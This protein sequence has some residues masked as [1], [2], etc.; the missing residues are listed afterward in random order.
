MRRAF[1]PGILALWAITSPLAPSWALDDVVTLGGFSL[2]IEG[3]I[4]GRAI[5]SGDIKSW[6]DGGLGKI[7]YGGGDGKTG[8]LA[9]A[10][11]ALVLEPKFGFD[12]SGAVVLTANA[13]QRTAVDISE[14][15]LQ[16]KPAPTGA[17][18]LK[19]KAG[20]F[21]PPISRENTGLAWT[22]PYTLTS[23]AINSWV[24]EELR[25]VGGEVTVFHRGGDLRTA[26]T[27]AIFIANDP[28][29]T[30][31]AWRGWSLNDRETG[32]F[33]R[34]RLAPIRIIS[35]TGGLSKQAPTEKP[36]HEIDGKPGF[37]GAV[38]ADYA[39]LGKLSVLYYDNNADDRMFEQGQWAWRTKF[40]GAGYRNQF[41][42]GFDVVAQVM[43]GS[44]SVITLP[45]TLGAIVDTHFWS[46]YGLVSKDRGKHRLSFRA[47]YFAT[48]DHDAFPDNNTEHGTALTL[49]YILRPAENQRLTFE[50]LHV[51]SR[52]PER[53]YLGLAPR[54]A[55]TQAQASYRFFF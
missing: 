29:G 38:E 14:A 4:E 24:G 12:W 43:R 35:P 15:Y 5:V 3:F 49:A 26:F 41:A 8:L 17:L 6:E 36:F 48:S 28:T 45:G 21:F 44:T 30:L 16:Y 42:D 31:L 20:A 13:Q 11:G 10:E 50:I 52:R 19:I 37:Y 2:N 54:A 1:R 32:F 39:D 51:N 23:S 18:G 25:T 27:G 47:E 53:S 22:S 40:W 33:D 46:G 9:R 34:L 7:R 55:E